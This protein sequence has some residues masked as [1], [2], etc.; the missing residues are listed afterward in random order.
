V[1]Y[2][3]VSRGF[4]PVFIAVFIAVFRKRSPAGL[5]FFLWARHGVGYPSAYREAGARDAGHMI[6]NAADA[7]I[8][9][10]YTARTIHVAYPQQGGRRQMGSLE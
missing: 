10:C 3:R 7:F 6:P 9:Q 8:S 1:F 4:H 5:R 2:I